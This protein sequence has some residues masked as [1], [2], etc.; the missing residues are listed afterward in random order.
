M[1]EATRLL[2]F[3]KSNSVTVEKAKKM[4]DEEL[5]DKIVIGEFIDTKKE[6]YLDRYSRL[7]K[8]NLAMSHKE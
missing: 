6:T 1:P 8:Q 5:K 2:E 7:I 3:F 4:T